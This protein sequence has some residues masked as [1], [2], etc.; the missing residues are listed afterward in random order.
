MNK[1]GFTLI[2]LLIVIAIIGILASVVLASLNSARAKGTDVAIKSDLTNI[3]S[4]AAIY[5]DDNSQYYASVGNGWAIGVCPNPTATPP[6]GNIFS[7][8]KIFAG[9]GDAMTK[10]G[11]PLKSQC[12]VTPT[13][14]AVAVELKTSDGPDPAADPDAWCVDSVGASHAFSYAVGQDISNAITVDSCTP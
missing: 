9:L 1:K 14:W 4:S 11:N 5:Y 3:R 12:I 10:N 2:E 7:D 13:T 6:T 8:T